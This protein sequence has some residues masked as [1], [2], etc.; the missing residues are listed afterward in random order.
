MNLDTCSI[1]TLAAYV[2]LERTTLTRTLKP[3]IEQG[4][5]QD[6]SDIGRRN[7][8]LHLKLRR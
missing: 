3:L 8:Q 6:V 1:S 7:R 2:G 5:I 4:F